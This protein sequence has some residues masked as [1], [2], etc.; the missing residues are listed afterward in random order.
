MNLYLPTYEECLQI[1]KENGEL[2]FYEIKTEIEG[3]K[4]SFFNYRICSFSDLNNPIKSNEN[5]NAFELRGLTFVFNKDGSLFK[6]FLLMNKFFNIN[7]TPCSMYSILKNLE[8]DNVYIKE[9]GSIVSF[10]MTPDKIYAKSKMAFISEQSV[11]VQ[12]IFDNNI[13]LQ[14]FVRNML[15][16]DIIPIFEF[17]SPRNRIDLQYD[18]TELILLRLRCNKTGKYL[19][20]EDFDTTGI[21]TA[22]SIDIKNIDELISL[23]SSIR[24]IEGWVVQFTNGKMVKI[25]GEHYCALHGVLTESLNRENDIIELILDNKI[26]DV[27][28]QLDEKDSRRKNVNQIIDIINNEIKLLENNTNNLLDKYNGDIKEFALN[29]KNHDFFHLSISKINGK[30]LYTNIVLRIKK[31]TSHLKQARNW[32]NK[33]NWF[34]I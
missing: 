32:L 27:L 15:E 26:D 17:V 33:R 28:G 30:D 2:K 5:I 13:I 14:N 22:V 34:K 10:I 11:E 16:N 7:Q 8:I 6:R 23:T 19:K 29:Y 20:F 18:N 31:E 21:K 4:I 24:D 25:K 1:C 9:D 12:N 3:Y